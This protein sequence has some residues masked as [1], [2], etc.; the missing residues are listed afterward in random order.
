MGVGRDGGIEERNK[1]NQISEDSNKE[2][3]AD[4][5]SSNYFTNIVKHL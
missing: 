5:F 1:S 4:I 3:L 2:D